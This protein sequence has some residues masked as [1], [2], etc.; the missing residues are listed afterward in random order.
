M[1]SSTFKAAGFLFFVLCISV[2]AQTPAKKIGTSTISGK[3]T[4]KG[5]GI[6]G[7]RVGVR[8]KDSGTVR[9]VLSATTD[10]EGN[11]RIANVPPGTYDI[12]P[13]SPKFVVTGYQAT[14]TLIVSEGEAY[15]GIDFTLVRGGVIT[16]RITDSDGR[17]VVEEGVNISGPE[18]NPQEQFSRVNRSSTT[19]DDRGVYRAYGLA[20]GKYRVSA[21]VQEQDIG[22]RI[23]GSYKRT[24]YSA[25]SDSNKPTL[26]EVT[27]DG[28]TANIDIVV[29]RL[30]ATFRVS[31]KIVDAETGKPLPNV[32]YGFE[33]YYENGGSST[34]GM[35]TTG[36]GEFSLDNVTPG[37]YAVF[38]EP[39]S[40]LEF[41]SEPVRF[42]VTDQDIKG[43]VIKASAGHSVSG[44]IIVDGLDEKAAR[45]LL[46]GMIVIAHRQI[47]QER[48]RRYNPMHGVVKHDGSFRLS[49]LQPGMFEFSIL[50]SGSGEKGECEITRI[51]RNGVVAARWVEVKEQIND[52][53]V[54][55]K[56]H[57][58]GIRG[59]VKIENGELPAMEQVH[60]LVKR[61]G[62]EDS[63]IGAP[64]DA[65]DQFSLMG[66][67][68]G[69]YE[70]YTVA[71]LNG[72][73]SS[74]TQQVVVAENQVSEVI[75]TLQPKN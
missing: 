2:V 15:D 19:T 31:G 18:A 60:V 52:L 4:V 55:V 21:G 73:N 28:E 34:S 48:S 54:F 5:N 59:V 12:M 51:E 3:I 66:L 40:T 30:Q 74:T 14:K 17:P 20:P 27:E 38:I 22:S 9:A 10:S 56:Y 33:K 67:K 42:E 57:R 62:S 35:T 29:R 71:N 24:Y 58:G 1:A 16:G 32:T 37:K 26:V 49:G 68:P 11:Y 47:E 13:G 6:A 43:L 25:P 44:V 7:V 23:G 36:Q 45:V 63:Y 50:G 75:V 46:N 39:S 64:L 61:A 72:K 69:V 70:I 41:Y 8:D 53:R 65:R